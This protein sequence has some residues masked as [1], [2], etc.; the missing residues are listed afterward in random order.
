MANSKKVSKGI[1]YKT[2]SKIVMGVVIALLVLIVG[3]YFTYYSGIVAR[4]IPAVK[5]EQTVDGKTTTIGKIYTP[6]LNYYRNNYISMYSMYGITADEEYLNTVDQA[7]GKTNGQLLYDQAAEQ[8]VTMRLVDDLA[9]KDSGFI[10]GASR[11]AEYQLYSTELTA[12]NYN[13]PTVGQYLSAV[14]G[15]GMSPRMFVE[16]VKNQEMFSEYQE[17]LK[18]FT[19]IPSEEEIQAVYNENPDAY[20]H[21]DFRWF[22]FNSASYDDPAAAALAV[23]EAAVSEND[24]QLAVLNQMDEETIDKTGFTVDSKDTLM[25]GLSKDSLQSN[26][27]PEDMQKYLMDPA[28]VG[29]AEVFDTMYGSYVVFPLSIYEGTEATYSY[30]RIVLNNKNV[31]N[32]DDYTQEE[33]LSGIADTQ[34]RADELMGTITD[35]TSFIK[36]VKEHTEAYDDITT[37]GYTSG[38][39]AFDF[40][41]ENLSED[42][43]NLSAWLL[44]PARKHG[45]MIAIKSFSNR[46][47]TIYYFDEVCESWKDQVT[48]ELVTKKANEWT[49]TLPTETTVPQISYKVAETLSYSA[50]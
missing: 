18:Q 10:S 11:F 33:L 36:A 29:K 12:K 3:G 37:A 5:I 46:K 19:F 8:I 48:N 39:M 50:Q 30:R 25:Q 43:K 21:C 47:V 26:A 14:Y 34:K 32:N 7:S 38:V 40:D 20:L 27:Y 41:S 42:D 49:A 15:S 31:E 28:N 17:Y 1:P 24:F 35:E 22:Y 2:K 9:E 44:D 13:Y 6:E 45:D 4:I 16:I 23:K